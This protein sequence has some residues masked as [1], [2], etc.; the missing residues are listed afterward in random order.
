MD[1]I[2][3]LYRIAGVFIS[4]LTFGVLFNIPKSEFIFCGLIGATGWIIFESMSYIL[5]SDHA[6]IFTSILVVTSLSRILSRHRKTITTIYLTIGIIPF[7]PG[8]GMYNTMYHIIYNQPSYAIISGIETFT[9]AGI[10]AIGVIVILSLPNKV[11][12][13]AYPK[14]Y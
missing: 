9:T 8:A 2:I 13:F 4:T 7:V 11:F 5:Y 10:I 14:K 6:S 12:E 1:F 3:I